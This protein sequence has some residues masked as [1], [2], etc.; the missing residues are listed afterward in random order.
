M[1]LKV[2]MG[3]K[4]FVCAQEDLREELPQDTPAENPF[5]SIT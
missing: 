5:H 2:H 3:E 1:H 4:Q